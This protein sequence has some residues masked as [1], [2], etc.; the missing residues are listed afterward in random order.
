MLSNNQDALRL[1][2]QEMKEE[3][4]AQKK[5]SDESALK[6]RIE[7]SL[8]HR[9]DA[10]VRAVKALTDPRFGQGMQETRWR[11]NIYP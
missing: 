10:L 8:A 7:K 3:K 5:A 11:S 6:S 2:L 1:R 4:L 9:Y